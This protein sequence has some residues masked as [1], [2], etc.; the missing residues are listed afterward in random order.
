MLMWLLYYA[1]WSILLFD[2]AVIA[3][4]LLASW[5]LIRRIKRLETLTV[6]GIAKDLRR[7]S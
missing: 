2:T 1:A 7:N 6:V 4:L 3:L 5:S